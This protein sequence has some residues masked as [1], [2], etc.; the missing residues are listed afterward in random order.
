LG[1]MYF[2]PDANNNNQQLKILLSNIVW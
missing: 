1:E 2:F